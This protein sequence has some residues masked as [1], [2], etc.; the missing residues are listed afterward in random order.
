MRKTPK[1]QRN[2]GRKRRRRRKR[3]KRRTK[4][5]GAKEV[6]IRRRNLPVEKMKRR[7]KKAMA[8]T[9]T[10]TGGVQ[11]D[12]LQTTMLKMATSASHRRVAGVGE[13]TTIVPTSVP[14]AMVNGDVVAI[15]R[16]V[17][18]PTFTARTA[19]GLT[20]T[21]LILIANVTARKRTVAKKAKVLRI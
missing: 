12:V 10:E 21:A 19:V 17:A 16:N 20:A 1:S 3:R 8:V 4:R 13:A 15:T 2:Q 7:R 9:S 11:C 5:K 18:A 14:L 6:E